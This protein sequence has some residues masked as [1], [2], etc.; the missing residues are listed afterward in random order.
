MKRKLYI[1]FLCI[2]SATLTGCGKQQ[3]TEPVT[4][5]TQ[6]ST[7]VVE[8]SVSMPETE[9][10]EE[11]EKDKQETP[12]CGYFMDTNLSGMIVLDEEFCQKLWDNPIDKSFEEEVMET[13]PRIS[14]ASAYSQ[15]WQAEIDNTLSVLEAYLS[16]EDYTCLENAYT[17]WQEYVNQMQAVEMEVFYN[18]S[19]YHTGSGMTY[20][21]VMEVKA[22]RVK[23]F[24]IEL[25]VLEY[26][27]TGDVT[28][29][30]DREHA[31]AEGMIKEKYVTTDVENYEQRNVKI[32]DYMY[33]DLTGAICME[34]EFANA[35]YNHPI[36]QTFELPEE[37]LRT[38]T[39]KEYCN[40]WKGEADKLLSE[41]ET[42]LTEEDYQALTQAYDGWQTYMDN[43]Q[44]VETKLFCTGSPY[45]T[46]S[47]ATE[48]RVAE[49]AAMR[50]RECVIGFA[51]S[52]YTLQEMVPSVF[53]TED[54]A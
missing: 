54:G 29:V 53:R 12:Q 19:E 13:T 23:M 51:S 25:K 4:I 48:P 21:M 38:D 14:N 44:I 40:A 16:E 22:M 47:A 11:A 1:A 32:H 28:F 31:A 5:Q 6:E 50:A 49:R 39:A 41:L 36:D 33:M 35:M 30:F 17:G 24:T 20:P 37:A 34:R 27:L 26:A 9:E 8:E 46:A 45:G 10:V 42:Y 43:L 2:I 7:Q 3:N 18:G 52:V 15:A